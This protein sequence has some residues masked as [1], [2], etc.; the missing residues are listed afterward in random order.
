MRNLSNLSL[1]AGALTLGAAALAPST[2]ATAADMLAAPPQM[3]GEVQPP[4]LPY[5][6]PQGYQPQGYSYQVA[7]GYP[8]PPVAYAPPPPPPIYYADAAPPYVAWP[9]PYYYGPAYW[10]GYGPRWGY[11]HWSRWHR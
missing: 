9:G 4:P 8:P 11:G 1:I 2:S 5:Y 6:P 10:G 3:Q 7:P